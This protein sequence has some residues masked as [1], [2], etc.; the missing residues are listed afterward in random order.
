MKFKFNWPSGFR[1]FENVDRQMDH[2]HTY[3]ADVL[4]FQLQIFMALTLQAP[5]L[6]H[7]A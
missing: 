4:R 3:R 5:F 7:N 2:R 6:P 1:M